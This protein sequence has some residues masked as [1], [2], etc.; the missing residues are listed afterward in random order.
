M[1]GTSGNDQARG[2]CCSAELRPDEAA[3][4]PK[5]ATVRARRGPD[6]LRSTQ[7]GVGYGFTIGC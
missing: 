1:I 2:R 4:R 6:R 5:A 3:R 7:L